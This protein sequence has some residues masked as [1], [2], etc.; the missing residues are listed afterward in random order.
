[1]DSLLLEEVVKCVVIV[2]FMKEKVSLRHIC[3]G[4]W[5][6]SSV[7]F[8][9]E[10]YLKIFWCICSLCIAVTEKQKCDGM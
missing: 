4:Y 5:E 1:M 9:C 3:L 7:G 10:K 8:V 2:F 6:Q